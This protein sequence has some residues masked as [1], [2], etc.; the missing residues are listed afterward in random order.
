MLCM[1][2]CLCNI[3]MHSLHKMTSDPVELELQVDVSYYVGS[4]NRTH[5]LCQN[6]TL[7]W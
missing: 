1:H 6:I 5:V 2:I 3:Y 4:R 7:N